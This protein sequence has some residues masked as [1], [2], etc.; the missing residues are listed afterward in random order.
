[1][2]PFIRFVI[3]THAAAVI[4]S[5]LQFTHCNY[6]CLRLYIFIGII[7]LRRGVLRS[8]PVRFS[9]VYNLTLCCVFVFRVNCF[10]QSVTQLSIFRLEVSDYVTHYANC[11]YVMHIVF[12]NISIFLS[13][14]KVQKN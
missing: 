14:T 7:F 13:V 1:M 11:V 9:V 3:H 8:G 5:Y 10:Y 4:H 2:T 12:S 6:Y